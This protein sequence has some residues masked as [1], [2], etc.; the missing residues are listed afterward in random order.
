MGVIVQPLCVMEKK[1]K[2]MPVISPQMERLFTEFLVRY[3]EWQT[4][5]KLELGWLIVTMILGLMSLAVWMYLPFAWGVNLTLFLLFIGILRRYLSV[6]Q[7]VTHLYINVHILHHHLLGKLE[8]GFCTHH[9]ECP[10]AEQFKKYVWER[11]RISL[12]GEGV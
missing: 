7:Q 11:Y 4:Y 1:Q 10:C 8:V 5:Q 12:Y 3:R 2:G 6:K 9:D